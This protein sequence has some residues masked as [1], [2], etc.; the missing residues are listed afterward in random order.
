M[1]WHAQVAQIALKE[2][3]AGRWEEGDQV[4]IYLRV[5]HHAQDWAI[6]VS[7]EWKE[8]DILEEYQRHKIVFSEEAAKRLPP[9]R[10]EDHQIELLPGAPEYIKC[11]AYPLLPSE[12][13]IEWE[14]VHGEQD[15]GYIVPSDSKY[16]AP[17]FLINKKD[18]KK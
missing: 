16:A 10:P 18:G 4:D 2:A 1:K 9:R 11:K 13:K 6:Q 12:Q 15:K 7:Q 17:I 3:I 8:E 14:F 5:T